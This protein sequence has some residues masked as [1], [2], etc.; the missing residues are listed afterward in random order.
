MTIYQLKPNTEYELLQDFV[1][2]Y[3]HSFRMGQRLTFLERFYLPYDDG[4]TLFFNQE[5][6]FMPG[7]LRE[8]GMFLHGT[9]QRDIIENTHLYMRAVTGAT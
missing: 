6:E 1:D 4:N 7:S 3:G 5:R 9:D 8:I 2:F